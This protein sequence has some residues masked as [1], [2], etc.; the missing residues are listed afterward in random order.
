[1]EVGGFSM[2]YEGA[3]DWDLA[4]RITEKTKN[5]E[6]IP[7]VL[8]QW[9][10]VSGSTSAE[11]GAKSYVFDHQL[12]CVQAHLQRQGLPQAATSFPSPGDP[13]GHLAN[14]REKWY[15][16][17]SRPKTRSSTC[18]APSDSLLERTEYPN[19]ELILVDN[20]SQK[21][22]TRATTKGWRRMRASG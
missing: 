2:D 12:E 6:H 10:Q 19:F 20:G 1:M 11:F 8:Y 17:S 9:R 15:R 5:I 14:S 16:S 4:F 13:T 7:R 18:A 22:K 3:Q 21:E